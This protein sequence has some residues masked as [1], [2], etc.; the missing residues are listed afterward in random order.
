MDYDRA[1]FDNVA[2]DR[3][4]E[5]W[6]EWQKLYRRISTLHKIETFVRQKFGNTATWVTPMR[7]GGYNN[8]YRML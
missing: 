3:S 8:L 2:W 4:D 1:D 7:I 6:E 5:A